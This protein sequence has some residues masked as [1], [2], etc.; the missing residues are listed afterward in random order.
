VVA[1][2]AKVVENLDILPRPDRRSIDYE[3]HPMPTASVLGSRGCPWDCFFC[4]VRPFYESLGGPLRRL[5]SPREVADE[6]LELHVNR[7]VPIFLFQDDDFLAGGK[8]AKLWAIEIADLIAAAG[9]AGELAFKISC[10]SD[11]IDEEILRRLM[12]GGLTHVYMGVESGDEE[13]L[14]NMNKRMKPESH[15]RAGRILKKL[16]LSFDFGFMMVDPFLHIS[17][18]S[19]K[20][21]ISGRVYRRWMDGSPVLPHAALRRHS[22]EAQ[23]G[24][25]G[26]DAGY[27]V[28]ARL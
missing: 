25:G 9:F 5:R 1:P 17:Q 12:A 26:P 28:R 16:G 6:M 18:H 3:S 20:H 7:K 10:R 24:G 22:G 15:L 2:L 14:I 11:E 19:A 13:E 4:G 21:I 27:C 8:N 23:T